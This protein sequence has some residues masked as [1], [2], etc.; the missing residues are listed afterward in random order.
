MLLIDSAGIALASVTGDQI[1]APR[2][3]CTLCGRDGAD[4][5]YAVAHDGRLVCFGCIAAD[6]LERKVGGQ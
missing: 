6:L 5:A 3:V 2:P 4:R 1:K